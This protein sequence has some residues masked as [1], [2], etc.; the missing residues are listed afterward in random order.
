M[1]TWR[2]M[3]MG[4]FADS[5][6]PGSGVTGFRTVAGA[7]HGLSRLLLV[8]GRLLPSERPVHLHFG[9]EMLHVVSGRLLIRVGDDRREC[10]PDAVVAV[11]AGVWH[12]FRVLEETVLEVV[13]EQR[14][15]AV[16]PV[17][18]PGG[19][20][21]LVEVHRKDMPWGRP[22]PEGTSWTL[23]TDMRRI[24]DSLDMHV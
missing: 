5:G 20:T 16:Y 8:V 15:G 23:D 12:G 2:E 14:M 11:P 17:R 10:G 21:D 1:L 22:P 6:P 18:R 24:L 13:A 19:H 4:F 3:R 9:E 7:G